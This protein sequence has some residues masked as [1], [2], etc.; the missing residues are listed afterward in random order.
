MD[1]NKGFV[2]VNDAF[3]PSNQA[4]VSVFDYGFLYGAGVYDVI[5]V[6]EGKVHQLS[7]HLDRLLGNAETLH[8][9][10]LQNKQELVQTVLQLV[11]LNHLNN[12]IVYLQVTL[13][14]NAKRSLVLPTDGSLKPTLVAF[15]QEG[16]SYPKELFISGCTLRTLAD[17]RWQR[18]D[19]KTVQLLASLMTANHDLPTKTTETLFYDPQT[20]RIREG[21]ATNVFCAYGHHLFTPPCSHHILPGIQRATVIKLI[22]DNPECGIE[23]HEQEFDLDFLRSADEIF[24]TS[25]SREVMPVRSVDGI[26]PKHSAPGSVT[27][28]IMRLVIEEVERQL[29]I[30]HFKRDY[31]LF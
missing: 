9:P 24:L 12:G 4:Q 13:G 26:S 29:Q 5:K 1:E 15:T 20:Q 19:I 28:K 22:R 16:P 31:R 30:T 2:F 25:T 6:Y 11:A 23:I 14:S 21:S 8:F 27:I 3:V 17:F 10:L 7:E 18:C